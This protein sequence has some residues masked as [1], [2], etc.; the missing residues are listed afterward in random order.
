[1]IEKTSRDIVNQMMRLN[2]YRCAD[3]K[4]GRSL[5]ES[6]KENSTVPV[7]ETGTG[8]CHIYVDEFADFDMALNIIDNAKTQ[9]L[10]YVTHESLVIHESIVKTLSLVIPKA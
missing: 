3:S 4:R 10:V 9:R 8:N 2:D 1:M 6:V 7:I 5:I